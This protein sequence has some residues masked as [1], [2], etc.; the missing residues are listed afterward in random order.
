MGDVYAPSAMG[1]TV[2]RHKTIPKRPARL[3]GELVVL[4]DGNDV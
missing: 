4:V 1:T 2:V 3:D